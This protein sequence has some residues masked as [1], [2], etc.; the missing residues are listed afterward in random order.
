MVALRS[1]CLDETTLSIEKRTKMRD[2]SNI[3]GPNEVE[4]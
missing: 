4:I 3:K 1:R 2:N